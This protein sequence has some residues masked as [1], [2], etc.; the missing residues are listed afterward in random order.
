MYPKSTAIYV[1]TMY[2]NMP[3]KHLLHTHWISLRSLPLLNTP[4]IRKLSQKGKAYPLQTSRKPRGHSPLPST[5]WGTWVS[6]WQP[7][8]LIHAQTLLSTTVQQ[9]RGRKTGGVDTRH[10]THSDIIL[11]GLN[12]PHPSTCVHDVADYWNIFRRLMK[13]DQFLP[14][15]LRCAVQRSSL[16]PPHPLLPVSVRI[17][18]LS[19]V[20]EK[21]NLKLYRKQCN[22]SFR[23]LFFFPRAK[24][25]GLGYKV[26]VLE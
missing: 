20:C 4:R 11:G 15:G 8:R 21:Y 18:R 26:N 14:T 3:H 16:F 25:T 17:Q 10:L 19:F 12:W 6:P 7:W 2:N 24:W 9:G 22:R 23:N 5:R 13:A 1:L